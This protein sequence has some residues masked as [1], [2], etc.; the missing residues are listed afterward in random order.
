MARR[1][2]AAAAPPVSA[3]SPRVLRRRGRRG[4]LGNVVPRWA[5]PEP[6]RP[7]PGAHRA[8]L[9]VTYRKRIGETEAHSCRKW[10]PQ[11]PGT[12]DVCCL[13]L[14]VTSASAAGG[15]DCGR[16][17]V[18][19]EGERGPDGPGTGSPGMMLVLLVQLWAL[20]G[21]SSLRVQQGP[22]RLQVRQGSQATLDCHVDQ[23]LAWERLR[24]VWTKD[25]NVTCQPYITN[26][27]LSQGLCGPQGRLSWQAPSHLTLRL[28]PVSLSH[29]GTY[30]CKA[31][32]EIP[33]LEKAEG[34]GTWLSVDPDDTPQNRNL[35]PSFRGL[36][37]VP[38]GVGSVGV[39]TMVLGA[40]F[41][42]RRHCQQRDSGNSPAQKGH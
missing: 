32:I 31:I 1:A 37:F 3:P 38:L 11:Q 10:S 12:P 5:R 28:D 8:L 39:A 21:A 34:N 27:H 29:S 20:Q 33:D 15:G 42:G 40:W 41:W 17:S 23:A 4:R 6:A 7:A 14:G 25:G 30:V 19:W 9:V 18:N 35:T 24:V 13:A 2:L 22:Q 26:G 16:K 36:L